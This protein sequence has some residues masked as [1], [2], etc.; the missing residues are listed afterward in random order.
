MY[1]SVLLFSESLCTA[2][3]RAIK[4][5]QWLSLSRV[6]WSLRTHLI[7]MLCFALGV[8]AHR[9]LNTKEICLPF[10]ASLLFEQNENQTLQYKQ[11]GYKSDSSFFECC[12][13]GIYRLLTELWFKH[14]PRHEFAIAFFSEIICSRS[15][16]VVSADLVHLW[17]PAGMTVYLLLE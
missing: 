13:Y 12:C 14:S 15:Q 5:V 9:A 3:E 6:Y 11:E 16:S 8:C 17:G 7:K 2:S 10:T 4:H 1:G